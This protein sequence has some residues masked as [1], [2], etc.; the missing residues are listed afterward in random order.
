MKVTYKKILDSIPALRKLTAMDFRVQEAVALAK[1]IKKLDAELKIYEEL[2]EKLKKEVKCEADF[3]KKVSELLEVECD[4]FEKVSLT[5][6]NAMSIDAQTL[7]NSEDFAEIT[8]EEV[9]DDGK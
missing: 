8:I 2:R 3:I 4:E 6:G 5:L 1:L 7:L 9:E